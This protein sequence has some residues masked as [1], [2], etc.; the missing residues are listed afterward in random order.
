MKVCGITRVEDAQ[1]SEACGAWAIGVIV[2]SDSPRS[3][4][5]ERAGEIFASL[6]QS[7]VTVAVTHTT[8]ESDIHDILNLYPTA[9]QVYHPF[10]VRR[11]HGVKVFRVV[12]RWDLPPE[13]C[14]ALIVDESHGRG[15]QF[16][17]SFAKDVVRRS[18]VP[19]ILAGGLTAENIREAVHLIH[20]YAVD[21][22]SGVE[23]LPGIKDREKV[24]TFL[25]ICREIQ[26]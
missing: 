11:E 6:S 25:D 2:C 19:V 14:D 16:D 23:V 7:I 8:S 20:P 24:K 22:S 12:N 26:G 15:R 3:V 4:S 5:L 18:R 1:F 10:H 21:V 13:N 9:V 17:P